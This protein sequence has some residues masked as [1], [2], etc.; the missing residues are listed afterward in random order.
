MN[1]NG[2]CVHLNLIGKRGERYLHCDVTKDNDFL[3]VLHWADFHWESIEY[4]LTAHPTVHFF[5]LKWILK[6][7]FVCVFL[8]FSQI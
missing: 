5:I 7:S 2:V 4:G 8:L 3:L 1:V 6:K